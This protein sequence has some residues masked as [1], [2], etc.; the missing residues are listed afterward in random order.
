MIGPHLLAAQVHGDRAL[1]GRCE[2][3]QRHFLRRCG[4]AC[5]RSRCG[6]RDFR[7]PR[8]GVPAAQ[9]VGE[10]LA[11]G[12]TASAWRRARSLAWPKPDRDRTLRGQ[13]SR[14]ARLSTATKG[15]KPGAP[16]PRWPPARY[17]A[18]ARRSRGASAT[19]WSTPTG[20]CASC[21][22]RIRRVSRTAPWWT[23]AAAVRLTRLV[24]VHREGLCRQRLRRREGRHGHRDRRRGSCAHNARDPQV[25]A[26]EA[27]RPAQ[28]GQC[29]AALRLGAE[30]R[31]PPRRLAKDFEATIASARA[32]LYAASVMLLVRRLARAA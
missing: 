11:S 24:S 9:A 19:R 10:D 28:P 30:G 7:R 20:A 27:V 8:R 31:E 12:T 32:F 2:R 23:E 1:D 21:S 6:S 25:G 14:L 17:D 29:R 15:V 26:D 5:P 3:C 16:R 4:L 13:P 22:R 18:E